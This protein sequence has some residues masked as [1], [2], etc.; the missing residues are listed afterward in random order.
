VYQ[1]SILPD[2]RRIEAVSAQHQAVKRWTFL[3][4]KVSIN[5]I[6]GVFNALCCR[7]LHYSNCHAA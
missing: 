2:W 4:M 7:L 3:F 6:L 5:V 1:N